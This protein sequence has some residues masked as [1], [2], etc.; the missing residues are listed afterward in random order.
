MGNDLPGDGGDNNMDGPVRRIGEP[1]VFAPGSPGSPFVRGGLPE[2][3][4]EKAPGET[5]DAA[6][7]EPS[8]EAEEVERQLAHYAFV[9]EER[10]REVRLLFRD[11]PAD[12]VAAAF[13]AAGASLITLR[14]ERSA[15]ATAPEIP[16]EEQAEPAAPARRKR[17]RAGSKAPGALSMRYF[18]ALGEIVYTVTIAS[19]SEVIAS[20]APIF[21]AAALRE[22]ELHER[23]AVAFRRPGA[24]LPED[25]LT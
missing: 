22:R 8:P 25:G 19:S 12:D 6:A 23:M 11:V 21:P 17:K 1:E 14:G 18:Y 5:E 10:E 4:Q 24:D 15:P 16:S 20:V 7:N 3:P 9:R 13:R 2:Q